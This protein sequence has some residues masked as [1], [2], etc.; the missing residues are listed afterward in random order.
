MLNRQ[1]G[2]PRLEAGVALLLR[3]VAVGG[4]E[5]GLALLENVTA[6]RLWQEGKLVHDNATGQFRSPAEVYEQ[7]GF[8]SA[9]FYASSDGAVRPL[10]AHLESLGCDVEHRLDDQEGLGR[11]AIALTT[12]VI[13]FVS[14]SI[15]NASANSGAVSWMDLTTKFKEIGIKMAYGVTRCDIVFAYVVEG[16]IVGV[17]A[18]TAGSIL[19]G[20]GDPLLRDLIARTIGLGPDFFVFPVFGLAVAWL[21]GVAGAIVVGFNVVR[22]AVADLAGLA[23]IAGGITALNIEA[24]LECVMNRTKSNECEGVDLRQERPAARRRLLVRWIVMAGI[25][26]LALGLLVGSQIGRLVD[27]VGMGWQEPRHDATDAPLTPRLIAQYRQELIRLTQTRNNDAVVLREKQLTLQILKA[28]GVDSGSPS[29]RRL[30]TE[31]S[32]LQAVMAR[33]DDRLARLRDQLSKLTAVKSAVEQE[34]GGLDVQTEVHARR[35]VLEHDVGLPL[36]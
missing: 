32:D 9:V 7:R 4:S 34:E 10:V 16:F 24:E 20:A 19:V 12:L 1:D 29:S 28:R 26:G 30:E 6:W 13:L 3:V 22:N 27:S 23:E 15:L 25:G 31:V 2:A 35:V 14:G 21:Y 8:I 11:L 18:C 33:S 5:Q 36:E 17:L